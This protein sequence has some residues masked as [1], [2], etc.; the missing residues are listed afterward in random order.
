MR[1]VV[2]SAQIWENLDE[3]ID[4]WAAAVSGK[5]VNMH[6][7][8]AGIVINDQDTIRCHGK[9]R[10]GA[11]QF[12]QPP[13]DIPGASV[14]AKANTLNARDLTRLVEECSEL[15]RGRE[16]EELAEGVPRPELGATVEDNTQESLSGWQFPT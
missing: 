12:R 6:Y 11:Q 10:G 5:R 4:M 8:M 9:L 7:T 3:G 13:Q 2:D 15:A 16:D 14:Y 1:R